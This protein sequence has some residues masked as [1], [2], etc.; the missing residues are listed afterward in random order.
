MFAHTED[1]IKERI[2]SA[3]NG[4]RTF[5]NLEPET[6][7]NAWLKNYNPV[8]L[9]GFKALYYH[10][11]YFFGII[12]KRET[13]QRISFYLREELLKFERYQKQF[14]FLYD[15]DLET[16]E[17]VQSQKDINENK[18]NEL[19][20]ERKRLYG[21]PDSEEEIEKI[22]KE[23]KEL[24]KDVRVCKNILEDCERV[25][26]RYEGVKWLEEQARIEYEGKRKP[27]NKSKDEISK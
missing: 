3:R 24:R 17:Q 5:S 19:V 4:I 10:Y 7:N 11:L 2:A 20:I 13:P 27:K 15:N 12:R 18:I 26:E 8:K 21:K 22:N 14:R 1:A 23:L 25:R 9:T 6:D 16:Q